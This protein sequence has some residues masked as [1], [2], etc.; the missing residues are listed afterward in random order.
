MIVIFAVMLS[1]GGESLLSGDRASTVTDTPEPSPSTTAL[2]SPTASPSAT[3]PTTAPSVSPTG[4]QATPTSAPGWTVSLSGSV[5]KPV[6]N[7]NT[8]FLESTLLT[9]GTSNGYFA[10]EIIENSVTEIVSTFAFSPPTMARRIFLHKDQGFS[11]NPWR[12]ILYEGG[13]QINGQWQGG[14]ERAFYPG[15]A[16]GC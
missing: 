6:P 8:T 1:G 13:T 4:S 16:T 2:A 14:V 3:L 12:I 9:Q 5:C 15:V 7:E 10:I 11:T